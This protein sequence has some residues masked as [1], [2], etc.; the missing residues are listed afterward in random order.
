M[1]KGLLQ[2]VQ[3][4]LKKELLLEW[5]QRYAF[6]GMLLYVGSSI[7]VCY[8]SFGVRSGAL[9]P[10]TWNALF[11]II[12]LFTAVNAVAKSFMQEREGRQLYLYTLASP[13]GII[14]AKILYNI[15]L[16]VLLTSIGLLFYAIVLGNPLEDISLFALSILLA[17]FSFSTTFTLISG[18][19]AKA[20]NSSVLM[21]ILGFPV[22]IP[23]LLMVIRMAKNA[24]DGL[25]WSASQ[26]EIVT[27]LA[28]NAIIVV[29][30]FMLFPYLWRS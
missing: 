23:T 29:V 7:V 20:G 25:D 10:I 27:L 12:M 9:Q 26:D 2:E 22:I 17:A 15:L 6:N 21:A 3:V 30:S 28:I 16:M 11:W 18:I 14:L 8:M 1:K 24:I 13:Q 5:R 4:L 19:A